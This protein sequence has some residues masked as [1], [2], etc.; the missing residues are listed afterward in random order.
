MPSAGI[1]AMR[2]SRMTGLLLLRRIEESD[3]WQLGAQQEVS[4]TIRES[5]AI[6]WRS[7]PQHSRS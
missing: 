3:R 7:V 2:Y 5:A 4:E 6:F 1:E